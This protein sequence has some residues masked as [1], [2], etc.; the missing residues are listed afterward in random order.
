MK[1][2]SEF[3]LENSQFL[4]ANFSIYLN[5]RFFVMLK[6]NKKQK[7]KT[8]KKTKKKTNNKNKQQMLWILIR[9]SSPSTHN[10]CFM[11]NWT[12]LL[13]NTVEPQ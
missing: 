1:E 8:Q 9:Y 11:D 3:L 10:I 6:N 12:K 2:I 5:R 4:V 13:L 7:K